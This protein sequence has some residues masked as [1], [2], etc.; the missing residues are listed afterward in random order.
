MRRVLLQPGVEPVVTMEF[1]TPGR[2]ESLTPPMSS[3]LTA[4]LSRPPLVEAF[5]QRSGIPRSSR[6]R[7]ATVLTLAQAAVTA[8]AE[9]LLAMDE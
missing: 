3:C 7:L 9:T 4:G 1:C 5:A 6:H 8:E 2:H